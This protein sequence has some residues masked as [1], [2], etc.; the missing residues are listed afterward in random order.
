MKKKSSLNRATCEQVE[1]EHKRSEVK[2]QKKKE[3]SNIYLILEVSQ[4]LP[5]RLFGDHQLFQVG[6]MLVP[7]PEKGG[8]NI[9]LGSGLGCNVAWTQSEVQILDKKEDV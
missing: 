1:L 5:T 9:N 8:N 7:D 4:H 3:I 2:E 6:G